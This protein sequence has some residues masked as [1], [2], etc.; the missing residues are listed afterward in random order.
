M[1]SPIEGQGGELS[2]ALKEEMVRRAEEGIGT[3]LS[4]IAGLIM[5][6]AWRLTRTRYF[7]TH[8]VRMMLRAQAYALDNEAAICETDSTDVEEME[9]TEE[10][11]HLMPPDRPSVAARND[12]H[13]PIYER[14]LQGEI[15][16]PCAGLYRFNDEP[17]EQPFDKYWPSPLTDE[18][19]VEQEALRDIIDNGV[20]PC[21]IL[22]ELIFK[23]VIKLSDEAGVPSSASRRPPEVRTGMGPPPPF[24]QGQ[25]LLE[26]ARAGASITDMATEQLRYLLATRRI[27]GEDL[28]QM[29]VDRFPVTDLTWLPC[30]HDRRRIKYAGQPPD[31]SLPTRIRFDG[32]CARMICPLMVRG[33]Q[34][35]RTVPCVEALGERP[36]PAFV[37][38]EALVR[39]RGLVP[40]SSTAAPL[41]DDSGQP[42]P[43]SWS[44]EDD[45][46]GGPKDPV[47]LLEMRPCYLLGLM[48]YV[49]LPAKLNELAAIPDSDPA[50]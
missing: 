35:D 36:D 28:A 13:C 29:A 41:V 34:G 43:Q 8:D 49:A 18:L 4:T 37:A 42:L 19:R 16:L 11:L 33:K 27:Y 40:G 15:Y 32:S 39:K 23:M 12:L 1:Q 9:R 22:A 20:S 47:R 45:Q 26:L 17:V 38:A 3:A 25:L 44:G 50:E 24:E 31:E 46:P 14:Y 48:L 2:P 30:R 21:H 6:M 7:T 10:Q 5:G